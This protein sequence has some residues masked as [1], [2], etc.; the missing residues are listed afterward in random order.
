MKSFSIWPFISGFISLKCFQSLYVWSI[1]QY[2]VPCSEQYPMARIYHVSSICQLW[3]FWLLWIM[4]LWT[5]T[6]SRLCAYMFSFPLS[7]VW[8]VEL[9]GPIFWVD[10]GSWWWTGKPGV[11]QFMGS[12]SRTRLSYWTELMASLYL[13]FWGTSKQLYHLTFL[14]TAYCSWGSPGKIVMLK[15]LQA[16]C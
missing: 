15:I 11:L 5:F 7:R 9:L 8:G 2:F 6:G 3:V 4:L 13:A 10:S 1:F 12:Q 14:S 16:R